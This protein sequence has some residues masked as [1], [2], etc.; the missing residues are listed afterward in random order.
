MVHQ[1]WRIPYDYTYL[2]CGHFSYQYTDKDDKMEA[3]CSECEV[4]TIHC[5]KYLYKNYKRQMRLNEVL[6]QEV[7]HIQ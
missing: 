3:W 2:D 5:K 1:Q 4:N 7:N 6:N